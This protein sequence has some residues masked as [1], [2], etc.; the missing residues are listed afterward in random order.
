MNFSDEYPRRYD[1]SGSIP[2]LPSN[3]KVWVAGNRV[4]PLSLA[5]EVA[6]EEVL[7]A[8][9]LAVLIPPASLMSTSEIKKMF[10]WYNQTNKL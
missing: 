5:G 3:T 10:N 4:L 2:G 7:D 6:V 9:L 1:H 8:F